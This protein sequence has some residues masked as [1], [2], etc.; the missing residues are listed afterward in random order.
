MDTSVDEGM[1]EEELKRAEEAALPYG[2]V[3]AELFVPPLP[4]HE[5]LLD[6]F[7]TKPNSRS[8]QGTY[9]FLASSLLTG[10]S[11]SL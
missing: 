10:K 2:A 5:H 11:S 4:L 8:R 1:V 3:E 6:S 9:R 7:A